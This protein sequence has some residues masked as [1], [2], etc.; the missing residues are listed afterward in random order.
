MQ[1]LTWFQIGFEPLADTYILY[2]TEHDCIVSNHWLPKVPLY[3]TVVVY[4]HIL[5]YYPQI[6]FLLKSWKRLLRGDIWKKSNMNS[7]T[8]CIVWR[9]SI[10]FFSDWPLLVV[11][12]CSVCSLSQGPVYGNNICFIKTIASLCERTEGVF[13]LW[14]TNIVFKSRLS[15]GYIFNMSRHYTE[16]QSRV[17]HKMDA[18]TSRIYVYY[19]RIYTDNTPSLSSCHLKGN[20]SP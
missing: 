6:L 1:Y 8:H 12:S 18:Q 15:R 19:R 9:L 11:S 10:V 3:Y 16:H 5:V 13:Q 17:G 20:I 2:Y 7:S 14:I 4:H